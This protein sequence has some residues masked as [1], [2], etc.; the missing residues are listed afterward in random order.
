M[1]VLLSRSFIQWVASPDNKVKMLEKQNLKYVQENPIDL[2]DLAAK[3]KAQM[4]KP[5]KKG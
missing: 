4:S 5:R 3:I 2:D 1:K